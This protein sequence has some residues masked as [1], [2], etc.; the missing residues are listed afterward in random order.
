MTRRHV[1]LRRRRVARWVMRDLDPVQ[2]LLG[3]LAVALGYA[4]G[5]WV[6]PLLMG[7]P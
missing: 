6:L 5:T 2:Y 1:Y 7:M 3:S 4:G